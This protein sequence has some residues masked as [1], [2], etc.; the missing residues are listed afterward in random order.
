M[1]MTPARASRALA[2]PVSVSA[3]ARTAVLQL[4]F[5]FLNSRPVT[6]HNISYM[7]YSVEIHLQLI[8]LPQYIV[9]PL[10]FL[11]CHLNRIS[12]SI[13]LLLSH[14]GRLIRQVL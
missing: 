6:P 9:K 5:H 10:Y 12:G 4:L 11:I 7:S 1:M 14:D 3:A 8:N 13:I 2:V